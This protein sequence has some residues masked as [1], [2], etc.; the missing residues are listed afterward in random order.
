MNETVITGN[1]FQNELKNLSV[2]VQI[3]DSAALRNS[4]GSSVA[5]IIKKEA[6]I[7]IR[8]YGA[9]GSLQSVSLRGMSS[10][11][12]LILVDGKRY[13]TFQIGTVDLGIFSLSDVERIE[14]I[15]G[16][17]SSL[18][19]AD[20]VGGVI[21]I[22]TKK[23][24]K[25]KYST[26]SH[27]IGSFGN[28]SFGIDV[29]GDADGV[30]IYAGG[31]FE[32]GKNN[33]DFRYSDGLVD[34]I[35][36]RSGSN[37][38][39]STFAFSASII[40]EDLS[41][42]LSFRVSKA[43]RGQPSP[44][45]SQFQNN[46]ARIN[47]EDA[48]IQLNFDWKISDKLLLNTSS[49]FR[50]NN[51]TYRDP[52]LMIQG[53]PLSSYYVNR[54]LNVTPT[55]QYMVH[56]KHQIYFGT[57]I[58]YGNISSNEVQSAE[59]YQFSI[60]ASSQHQFSNVIEL[61]LYPSIRYDSFNDV[62]EDISPK[63]GFNIG[64][65]S[66][67]EIRLR[68]SYGKN[69]RVPTFNDLYWNVGG[70]KNIRPE[71][72]LSGD[73]GIVVSTDM[74]G[75]LELEA[76]YFSIKT[77]DKIVWTPGESNIWVPLNVSA[78][79]STGIEVRTQASFFNDLL[80][81]THNYTITNVIKT[82]AEVTNDQ[83]QGKRLRYTPRENASFRFGSTFSDLSLNII[84]SFTGFRYLQSD[85]N[86]RFILSSFETVDVNIS[87]SMQIDVF[88]IRLKG[89]VNNLF[90]EEYSFI[91][92]YPMPLRNYVFSTQIHLQ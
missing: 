85:N 28:Q 52:N 44:V 84:Y 88:S 6:G 75:K 2:S 45:T 32:S 87:Y 14:I 61:F 54:M 64:L 63:I 69:Y 15:K 46:L 25:E 3:I 38:S 47:D 56:E 78:V 9:K 60:F 50:F 79:S 1:R 89:E 24:S 70:N 39:L 80:Q 77:R 51:E 83:T 16:G 41:S 55:V 36:Q 17:N 26:I 21:N 35:L 82:S 66:F 4:N 27:S 34:T 91:Y 71:R 86:P 33:F 20:A 30:F 65:E 74:I 13:T 8:S 90:N 31:K 62:G 7:F 76:N 10:D 58:A 92:G 22:I 18:F 72:L 29:G 19:G 57:E 5:D 11:Y 59:R 43:D 40:G 12:T 53:I 42:K 48:I 68:A 67:P 37:Y 73:A 23:G 81:L 49:S